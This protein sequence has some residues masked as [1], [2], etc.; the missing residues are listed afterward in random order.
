MASVE[1]LGDSAKIL[2]SDCTEL[3]FNYGV[4]ENVWDG[5]LHKSILSMQV[6]EH[7]IMRIR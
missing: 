1:S 3:D 4:Q 7:K 5:G 6:R 2:A